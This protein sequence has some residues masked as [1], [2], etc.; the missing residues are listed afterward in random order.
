MQRGSNGGALASRPINTLGA[1]TTG[2]TSGGGL[3]GGGGEV[4]LSSSRS[5]K[6]PHRLNLYE[7]PPTDEVTLEEFEIWAIDRL[8]R[9]S[10]DLAPILSCSPALQTGQPLKR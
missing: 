1:S 5:T 3:S 2:S 8:R 10:R 4:H 6:Y 9:E 7:R